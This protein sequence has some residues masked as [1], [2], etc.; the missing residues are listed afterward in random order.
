MTDKQIIIDGVNVAGCEAYKPYLG[1]YDCIAL[2]N[3]SAA[4]CK[5]SPNCLFKQLAR[6]TQE[7]EGIK[8]Q[9]DRFKTE[10]KKL[11]DKAYILFDEAI[12]ERDNFIEEL[13]AEKEQAEQKREALQMSDNEAREIVAELKAECKELK[14]KVKELHQGW[15]DCDKERNLQEA[16]SEF[17]Q[18][19]IN[20]YKQTFAE[21]EPVLELYANTKIGV[22]KPDGTSKIIIED[23]GVLGS[24]YIT[25]NPNPA[26]QA[27]Q[28]INEVLND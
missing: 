3:K 10:N 18:R 22:E 4:T 13:K 1:K 6:K 17:R 27:L 7:C 8:K 12:I 14:E 24:T 16:N 11:K 21:I 28:K 25:F 9:L 2:G 15:I 19:V 26:K 23:L 5:G 20:Q